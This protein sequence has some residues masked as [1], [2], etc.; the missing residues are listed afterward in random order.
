MKTEG[1]WLE[2]IEKDIMERLNTGEDVYIESGCDND[3]II[4]YSA[5][6]EIVFTTTA[7]IFP[8]HIILSYWDNIDT[9]NYNNKM[10]IHVW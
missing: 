5:E 8:K 9:E 3:K 1:F 4:G 2:S 7:C 10:F 6:E